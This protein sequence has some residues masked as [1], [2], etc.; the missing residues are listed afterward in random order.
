MLRFEDIK[1]SY[2]PRSVLQ[3]LSGE[4]GVGAWALRGPNGIGKST[5]LKVL[6]GAVEPD[7]G[8]V[9]VDGLPLHSD[10]TAARAR[11]AYAPDECPV[12]PFMTGRE[13]L[14]F[15]AW[16]KRCDLSSEVLDIV[17]GFGLT[18]HLDTRCGAMSLGTQKKLMLA[19]GWIGKPAVLLCDEPSN[20]LDAQT[21]LV[22]V[23][24]LREKS[25]QATVLVSTHD[26]A[27]AQALG[28]TVLDFADLHE[29]LPEGRDPAQ[30]PFNP[31]RS[32]ASRM[33]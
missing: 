29:S 11:L 24:L 7:A 25:L 8:A 23:D 27:F 18:R 10:P 22:L 9:W 17:D 21:R 14:A 19:A 1:K 4:F 12:Y 15:V 20:G 26:Q 33:A 2:G 3:G 32:W 16:A 5:L 13:L 6:A 30:A 28:A 31:N